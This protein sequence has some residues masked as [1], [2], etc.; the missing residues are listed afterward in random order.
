MLLRLSVQLALSILVGSFSVL[1][2]DEA[3]QNEPE[4]FEDLTA[5]A[6]SSSADASRYRS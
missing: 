5:Y 2:H 3:R 1:A 4:L 6:R